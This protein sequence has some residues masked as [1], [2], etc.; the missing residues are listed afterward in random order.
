MFS[1]IVSLGLFFIL[2]IFWYWHPNFE[3]QF[4]KFEVSSKLK[5]ISTEGKHVLLKAVYY[6][7]SVSQ[8]L[9]FRLACFRGGGMLFLK[10]Y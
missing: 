7:H 8:V 6:S 3:K 5:L 4:Q 9:R 10:M 2:F 1:L